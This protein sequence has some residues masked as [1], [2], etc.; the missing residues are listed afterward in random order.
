MDVTFRIPD[1][2]AARV[3]EGGDVS[4]RALEALATEAYR[5][6]ILTLYELSEILGL[7]RVETEDFLGRHRV[8]L[9]DI[10][11]TELDREAAIFGTAS[12]QKP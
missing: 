10:D 11:G 2:I 6:R 8:P 3:A 7:S 1:A 12:R 5:D 4:R 9:A